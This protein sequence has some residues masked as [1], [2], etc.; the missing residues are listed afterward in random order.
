MTPHQF[1]SARRG[2]W[3]VYHTG[4]YSDLIGKA[5]QGR[6]AMA[7]YKQGRAI[8]VQRKIGDDPRMYEYIAVKVK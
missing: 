6:L 5:P 2:K 8:L 4:D 1:K 3:I 7:L